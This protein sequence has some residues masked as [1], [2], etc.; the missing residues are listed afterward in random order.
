MPRISV[1][2]P[3]LHTYHGSEQRIGT[4]E[5]AANTLS[6]IPEG[7]LYRRG[8]MIGRVVEDA[9][10]PLSSSAMRL[11]VDEHVEIEQRTVRSK[12]E[13]VS[14]IP[15]SSELAAAV[16]DCAG[17]A[18][19]FGALHQRP[20]SLLHEAGS[21]RELRAVVPHPVISP[22]GK[23]LRHGWHPYYGVLVTDDPQG[24]PEPPWD[25]LTDFQLDPTSQ[26]NAIAIMLTVLCRPILGGHVPLFIVTAPV[27]GSGKTK[28]IDEIV[29]GITLGR[30]VPSMLWPDDPD[31]IRKTLTAALVSGSPLLSL[32]NVPSVLDSHAL[33]SFL[34]TAVWRDRVLGQT[35]STEVPNCLTLCCTGNQVQA[36]GELARRAVRVQMAPGC[37]NPELR[38][39]WRYEDLRDAALKARPGVLAWLIGLVEAWVAAGRTPSGLV[40]GSFEPWVHTVLGP[41]HFSGLPVLSDWA[42]SAAGLDIE[43]RDLAAV[44][45]EW[46]ARYGQD[47]IRPTQ[48]IPI[49][50]AVG[51]WEAL[52]ASR[53]NERG[54]ATVVGIKLMRLVG[55]VV[56]DLRLEMREERNGRMYRIVP[57]A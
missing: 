43:R 19:G 14:Y 25:L 6:L 52:I 4:N 57:L 44:M 51:A 17:T 55:R 5:F 50:D 40:M 12:A 47:W 33:A 20:G 31:E 7:V 28:L 9:F 23:I 1:L 15:C 2:A 42:S 13:H 29:G 27:A 48:A 8:G 10:R 41:L 26:A 11:V 39:G 22:S 21:I 36:S 3:G 30:P 18:Q 37:D 56:G 34:T 16:L 45:A 35:L 54:Q 53:M 32:D 24:E 38:T 46:R 49:A